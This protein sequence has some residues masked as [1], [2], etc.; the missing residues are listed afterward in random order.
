M[1]VLVVI[2]VTA[3]IT[4]G[5]CPEANSQGVVACSNGELVTVPK[6]PLGA[7]EL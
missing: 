5:A 7:T 4:N 1:F 6:L 3:A 2:A